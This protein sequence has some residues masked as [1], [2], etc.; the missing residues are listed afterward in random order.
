MVNASCK[1][2]LVWFSWLSQQ[3]A[4]IKGCAS[5]G[6]SDWDRSSTGANAASVPLGV[7]PAWLDDLVNI[8][9][10]S[11]SRSAPPE[12]PVHMVSFAE[13][14]ERAKDDGASISLGSLHC[15]RVFV[16]CC[17]C[18]TSCALPQPLWLRCMHR[19]LAISRGY[20]RPSS[21]FVL[22]NL[23][24][25]CSI[26]G[27]PSVNIWC[28]SAHFFLLLYFCWSLTILFI[29]LFFFWC[30]VNAFHWVCVLILRRRCP[31]CL[32]CQAFVLRFFLLIRNLRHLLPLSPSRD[33]GG[34]ISDSWEVNHIARYSRRSFFFSLDLYSLIYI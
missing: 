8:G 17:S 34:G 30:L 12:P 23:L 1:C 31:S 21:L 24:G 5:G 14:V 10:S 13:S 4:A 7:D 19:G 3:P 33:R 9:T 2:S 20:L 15:R 26:I 18:F 22:Q 29:Y 16:W 27:W 25:C 6:C 32:E 11:S 28:C